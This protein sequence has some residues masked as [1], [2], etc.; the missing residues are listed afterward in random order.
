MKS[1]DYSLFY[2]IVF[3]DF[4]NILGVSISVSTKLIAKFIL[5]MKIQ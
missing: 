3:S 5:M 2:T 4:I 1:E